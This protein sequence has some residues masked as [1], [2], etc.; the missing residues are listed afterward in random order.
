MKFSSSDPTHVVVEHAHDDDGDEGDDGADGGHDLGD[1]EALR[2]HEEALVH[3]D[4]R[5]HGRAAEREDCRDRVYA[6][7]IVLFEIEPVCSWLKYSGGDHCQAK[8]KR[9]AKNNI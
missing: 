2:G 8:N 9:Q 6:S 3:L 4:Q 7:F 1:V 5:H